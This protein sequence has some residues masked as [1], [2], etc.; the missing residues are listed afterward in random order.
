MTTARPRN[1]PIVAACTSRPRPS[2]AKRASCASRSA[3]RRSSSARRFTRNPI[4]LR[5]ST[6]GSMWPSWRA[7]RP[8]VEAA[9]A[10]A[11][12]RSFPVSPS[13]SSTAGARAR[14]SATTRSWIWDAPGAT[15]VSAGAGMIAR[16]P[17]SRASNAGTRGLRTRTQPTSRSPRSDASSSPPTG[18]A[19]GKS[20]R[21]R[22]RRVVTPRRYDAGRGAVSGRRTATRS[23]SRAPNSRSTLTYRSARKT[24]PSS[25]SR[26]SRAQIRRRGR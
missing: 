12:N 23:S 10:S 6:T 11:A 9:S 3:A 4:T 25:P 21:C 26:D 15:T 7:V 5:S 13:T 22:S 2:R 18:R 1:A 17:V 8:A 20:A 24:S 19:V 16:S 14:T